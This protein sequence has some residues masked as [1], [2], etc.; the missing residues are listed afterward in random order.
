ME[1]TQNVFEYD[2]GDVTPQKCLTLKAMTVEELYQAVIAS[3]DDVSAFASG[4]PYREKPY[5]KLLTYLG[6]VLRR[7]LWK[8][9]ACEPTLCG[10]GQLIYPD[11]LV[12][13][14]DFSK[15]VGGERYSRIDLDLRTIKKRYT[16]ELERINLV[17][18]TTMKLLKAPLLSKQINDLM[19]EIL[20]KN[21]NK[22]TQFKDF[23]TPDHY[24]KVRMGCDVSEWTV[25]E[26]E[27][28]LACLKKM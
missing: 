3:I 17:K 15:Y 21:G 2:F 16:L 13:L 18:Q 4:S 28:L 23:L 1:F 26:Q 11:M 8:W 22:P 25:E 7:N 9:D 27:V 14:F 24:R 20:D 6:E 10:D 19:D 12:R 5:N